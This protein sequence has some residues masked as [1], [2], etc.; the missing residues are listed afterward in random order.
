MSDLPIRF[1][2]ARAWMASIPC[3][4]RPLAERLPDRSLRAV[5]VLPGVAPLAIAVFQCEDTS[6]GPHA[7]V[8]LGF[9]VRHR[10]SAA[11]P[12]VPLLAE[13]WLI[14]LGIWVHT[15][16]V[17]SPEA[18]RVART[19]LGLPTARAQIDIDTRVDRVACT[20]RDDDGPILS[21]E[22][23]RPTAA[24]EPMHFPLR[25]WSKRESELLRTDF[26]VDAVG[27]LR[28]VGARAKL[29]LEDHPLVGHLRTLGLT[30]AA[31]L[32]VRWLDA[33]HTAL[34]APA[35]RFLLDAK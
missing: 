35:A 2:K 19:E 12:L 31:P 21:V 20:V 5:S 6:V 27:S 7:E 28:R 29:T 3:P 10:K 16:A 9:P 33:Y 13:R 14:D 22:I 23:E 17:D 15:F 25:L 1:R 30:R 11:V 32:E 24:N 34:D 4:L 18:E 8:V 26:D